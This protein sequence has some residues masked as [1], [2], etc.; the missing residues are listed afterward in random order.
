MDN[1]VLLLDCTLRDGGYVN[2]WEFGHSTALCVAQRLVKAGVDIIELGFLDD[3]SP[4]TRHRTLQPTTAAMDAVY[5]GLE[6]QNSLLVGMIDYGTCT[7][8]NIAPCEESILD[9]IRIIFKRFNLRNAIEFGKQIKAK[10]Y[11]VFMQLVSITDYDDAGILEMAK[12]MS[13]L[14]PYGI[15]IVDTYG[16]MHKEEMMHYFYMMDRNLPQETIIGYHPHNNFQLAYSNA[17]ELI[18]KTSDSDRTIVV[19]GTVYGMGKSAGN[20]P[21]ELLAM[22]INEHRKTK[23]D[24]SQILEAIDGS[25]MPLYQRYHWG[26]SLNFFL[27]ALNDCH[28]NYITYL[29]GKKTLSVKAINEIISQIQPEK[30]LAYDKDHIYSLYCE[31]QQQKAKSVSPSDAFTELSSASEVLLLA[32]GAS[33]KNANE[34][35][36]EYIEKHHPTVISLNCIPKNYPL[37]YVFICNSK[38]LNLMYNAFMHLPDNVTTIATS[39]VENIGRP[40]DHMIDY[41][42][43]IDAQ[44]AVIGDNALVVFLHFARKIGIRT[45]TLAGCD[46]FSASLPNYSEGVADLSKTPY[47]MEEI[48]NHLREFI[49]GVQQYFALRF[50]T[51]SAYSVPLN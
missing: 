38:R 47:E 50:L 30:K 40:F 34:Q 2:N 26:Y 37:D 9:G 4:A 18:K 19:D 48:N 20:A 49:A 12:M 8:D 41:G 35:I 29:L 5:A 23:Y 28:P 3:R 13:E 17:I 24:I 46:G 32:P 22:Y 16:L 42:D 21:L 6:K 10:G 33:L 14:R 25:I 43:F 11:K 15:S 44:D 31:Y 27:S 39:N 45:I 51:P 7:I 1:K 36:L